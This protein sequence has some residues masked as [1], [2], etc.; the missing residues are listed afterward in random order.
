MLVP[1]SSHVICYG[2]MQ[3]G[4][5]GDMWYA[6]PQSFVIFCFHDFS[7]FYACLIDDFFDQVLQLLCHS[8]RIEAEWIVSP[9]LLI[10]LFPS[11]LWCRSIHIGSFAHFGFA[12]IRRRLHFDDIG[13]HS[14][15]AAAAV[16]R[17]RL[18]RD[19]EFR[20]QFSHYRH[21]GD[22]SE[23]DDA[24]D[25]DEDEDDDEH[26]DGSGGYIDVNRFDFRRMFGLGAGASASLTMRRQIILQLLAQAGMLGG[27]GGDASS[28]SA[29][30]TAQADQD[31]DEDEEQGQED[32]D[33]DEDSQSQ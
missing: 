4:P 33:E 7:I 30:A 24:D 14:P 19:P 11:A 1:G 31:Q 3:E 20:D 32:E 9:C 28:A 16:P 26:G 18:S 21:R 13:A 6:V 25:G 10:Y 23:D 5:R 17:Y 15:A 22:D 8:C 2:G 29:A 27:G 12:L